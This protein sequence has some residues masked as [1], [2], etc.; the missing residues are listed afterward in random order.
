M[1][2]DCDSLSTVSSVHTSDLSDCTSECEPEIQ[3]NATAPAWL[4]CDIELAYERSWV[5]DCTERIGPL[6]HSNDSTACEIF[7]HFLKRFD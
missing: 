1:E 4:G 3:G 5:K 6:L 7:S 2:K